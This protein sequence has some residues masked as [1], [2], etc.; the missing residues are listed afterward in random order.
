MMRGS[1]AN[2][3]RPAPEVLLAHDGSLIPRGPPLGFKASSAPMTVLP[4]VP[5]KSLR[6]FS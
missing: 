5:E 3:Q 6:A 4:S 1:L 2:T